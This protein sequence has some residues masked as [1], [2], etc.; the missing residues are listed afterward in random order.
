MAKRHKKKKGRNMNTTNDKAKTNSQFFGDEVIRVR[1]AK[2]IDGQL[3]AAYLRNGG[4]KS[5]L[6]AGIKSGAIVVDPPEAKET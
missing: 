1:K 2:F 5:H 4:T 6:R 3:V